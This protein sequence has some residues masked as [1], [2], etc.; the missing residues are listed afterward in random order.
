MDD[1]SGLEVDIECAFN[2]I[3]LHDEDVEVEVEAEDGE[4]EG[5]PMVAAPSSKTADGVLQHLVDSKSD[6]QK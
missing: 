3:E 6:S 5:L 1:N 2:G 4:A